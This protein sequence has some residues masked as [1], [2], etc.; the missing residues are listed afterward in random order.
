MEEIQPGII[1]KY[2]LQTKAIN[3]INEAEKNLRQTILLRAQAQGATE[4]IA[5]KTKEKMRLM[6]EGTEGWDSF[7]AFSGDLLNLLTTAGT[8]VL[9]DDNSKLPFGGQQEE[10]N[11]LVSE[12]EGEISTLYKIL[13]NTSARQG[14]EQKRDEGVQV[15]G[16]KDT[17]TGKNKDYLNINIMNGNG[18]K[19]ETDGTFDSNVSDM[20]QMSSTSQ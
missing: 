18:S 19:I 7:N 5:E 11:R 16:I 17:R 10:V 12:K 1:E 6:T 15:F 13:E 8:S 14:I 20:P 3:G 2:N 4:M 9:H